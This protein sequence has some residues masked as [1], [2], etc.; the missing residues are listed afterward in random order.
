MEPNNAAYL[1]SMGW[2]YFREGNLEQAKLYLEKANSIL[3]DKEVSLH[4]AEVYQAMGLTNKAM[5]ILRPMLKE[6]PNDPVLESFMDRL[7]LRF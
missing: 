7:H 6:S 4:L 5:D 1:D 2:L 3:K